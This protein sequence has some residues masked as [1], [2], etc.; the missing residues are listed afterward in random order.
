[1]PDDFLPR[2]LDSFDRIAGWFSPDAL[3]LFMAYN[4]LIAEADLAGDVLEIGVHHGLSAIGTAAL[5]GPGARFV[6]V[7]LFDELQEQ[8]V[9]GSGL[10]NR[11]RFMEN[12]SR[13]HGDLGFVTAIA[14]ASSTID[15]KTLGRTFSFCHIDGGHAAAEAFADLCLSE[16]I[17]TPGGLVA[18]DDYFN[19]AFPGVGEAGV[20]YHLERPGRFRPIAIGFNKV[21]FQREPVPF[22]LNDRLGE[23]FPSVVSSHARLWDTP[24]RLFDT[25]FAAFFDRQRSRPQQLVAAEGA[26]VAARIEPMQGAVSA[27]AGGFVSVAVK[28]T[29]LSRV[30]FGQGRAP[31]G[32]SYHLLNDGGTVLEFDHP[33]QWFAEPLPP[34]RARIIEVPIQVPDAAGRYELV[35]DIV[36]EGVLWMK[37]RGN[38]VGRVSLTAVPNR[39]RPVEAELRAGV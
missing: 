20:R 3:F 28:V 16:A 8:N 2:Y 35:F 27:Q 38:P 5:R 14:A 19:P 34:D 1:M 32:L 4:Q 7:D 37:D 23:V 13:F 26:A 36:W 6:A 31:F 12:M 25:T 24:V 21:L 10:G 15:P 30:V 22:A 39:A 11:A 18:L 29:N 17:V 33:R 9:S